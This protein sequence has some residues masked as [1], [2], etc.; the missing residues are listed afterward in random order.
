MLFVLSDSKYDGCM[1]ADDTFFWKN[2]T[3]KTGV[4]NENWALFVII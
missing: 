3:L 1:A 4:T 2:H